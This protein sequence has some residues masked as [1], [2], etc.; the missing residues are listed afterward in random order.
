[1]AQTLSKPLTKRGRFWK[2]HVEQW[3]ATNVTQI[4]YCKDE[5]I[6][7]C[8]FRWWR[9]RLEYC[10]EI[11]P[12]KKRS[13]ARNPA[14]TF[15]EVPIHMLHEPTAEYAYAITLPNQ[16]QLRVMKHFEPEAVTTLLAL[17]EKTC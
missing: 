2:T 14:V 4:Q 13:K 10:G 11:Q 1:M 16:V 9:R 7:L 8:A 5:G 12:T 6:S 17:M 3:Q 15:A